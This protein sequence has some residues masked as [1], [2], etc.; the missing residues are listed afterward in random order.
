MVSLRLVL[1]G[2]NFKKIVP[3][4][5]NQAVNLHTNG[6]MK[7]QRVYQFLVVLML[8]LPD[9]IFSQQQM[10]R[11]G[12]KTPHINSPGNFKTEKI[13]NNSHKCYFSHN[14]VRRYLLSAHFHLEWKLF[15]PN[16]TIQNLPF[17]CKK[18]SS[19]RKILLFRCVYDL[20]H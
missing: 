3:I 16:F 20:A 1:S 17:F 6:L 7:S 9:R 14:E 5:K 18:N 2:L 13:R 12:Q 15:N 11:F 8:I 4:I 10:P 19:L